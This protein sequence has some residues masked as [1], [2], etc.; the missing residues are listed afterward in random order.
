VAKVLKINVPLQKKHEVLKH[1][2]DLKMKIKLFLTSILLI[3]ALGLSAQELL[4]PDGNSSRLLPKPTPF[5]EILKPSIDVFRNFEEVQKNPISAFDSLP[6]TWNAFKST[7]MAL[8]LPEEF[9][10]IE[11]FR[12]NMEMWKLKDSIFFDPEEHFST[13]CRKVALQGYSSVGGGIGVSVIQRF[14]DEFSREGKMCR[15]YDSLLA[16]EAVERQLYPKY[17]VELVK[18]I[19]GFTTDSAAYSFMRFCDFKNDSLLQANNYDVYMMVRSCLKQ[20]LNR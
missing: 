12:R 7:F 5:N 4:R 19:T 9:V 3:T 1:K 2:I 11:R 13:S 17:N 8:P 6:S 20:F 15:K 14:Y 16:Q 10:L 18:Q